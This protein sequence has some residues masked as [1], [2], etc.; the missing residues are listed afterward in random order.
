MSLWRETVT[1]RDGSLN[2]CTVVSN[3]DVI[4]LPALKVTLFWDT[5]PF[6][7]VFW[8]RIWKD[9]KT[10][11][12]LQLA[13]NYLKIRSSTRLVAGLGGFQRSG[14]P[15][16]SLWGL[17][18]SHHGSHKVA[19]PLT[20]QLRL[21]V[22]VFQDETRQAFADLASAA[23][24][25]HFHCILLAKRKPIQTRS[26]GRR[27]PLSVGSLPRS[28]HRRAEHGGHIW[29]IVSPGVTMEEEEEEQTPLTHPTL[30]LIRLSTSV[31][32]DRSSYPLP[33]RIA[34]C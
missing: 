23:W 4:L 13:L 1:G 29:R 2:L 27:T 30:K 28:H 7:Y 16:T 32:Y 15:T 22:Q 12:T 14:L 10:G 26:A 19:G 6:V 24:K 9:S 18:S 21:Q 17:A 34:A 8:D 5:S 11:A 25:H 3:C 33:I 20:Q 31:F